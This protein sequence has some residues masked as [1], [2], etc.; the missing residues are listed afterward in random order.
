[1]IRI[2]QGMFEKGLLQGEEWFVLN[3]LFFSTMTLSF[4]VI[5]Y[6]TYPNVENFRSDA[7][8][9]YEMLKSLTEKS[10]WASLFSKNLMVRMKGTL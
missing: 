7:T 10:L 2:A 6:K 8:V 1:M 9:G 4:I 5:E 3:A